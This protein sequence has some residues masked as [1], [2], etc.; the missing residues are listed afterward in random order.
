MHK[1]SK[2]RNA[3]FSDDTYVCCKTSIKTFTIKKRQSLICSAGIDM[4]I[5]ILHINVCGTKNKSFIFPSHHP[6]RI[7]HIMEMKGHNL[8]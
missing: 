1:I 6:V 5:H 2:R 7:Q 8:N 4:T 3:K